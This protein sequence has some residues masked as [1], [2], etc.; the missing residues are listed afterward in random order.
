MS[1]AIDGGVRVATQAAPPPPPPT[2]ARSV[3]AQA[4]DPRTGS[5]DTP[6][7]AQWVADVAR[8]SP[9]TASSAYAGIEAQL[10][11]GDV[12]RLTVDV[13]QAM[14]TPPAPAKREDDQDPTY[15]AYGAGMAPDVA[16]RRVL[17][18]NPLLEVQWRSTTSP[19]TGRSGF[20]G[21]LERAM[22]KAGIRHDFAVAPRPVNGT[23]I[24]TSASKTFNGHAARDAIADQL[25]TDPRYSQVANEADG[26]IVRQTS[27]GE[28]H[29]D[30]TAIRAGAR[31]EDNVRVDVESKLGSA[32]GSRGPKGNLAQVAKDGER[33]LENAGIRRIGAVAE[34]VG[35]VARPAGVVID[36]VQI[37]SAIKADGGTFGDNSQRAAGSLVGG[38]AG[39]WGGAQAGAAIGS[40]GGPVGTVVGGLAG[41]AIGGIVGS[42]VGEK[43]VDWVKGWF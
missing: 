39:A 7:L 5:V 31:P 42:G 6:R 2:D 33:I 16:G 43:A 34:G 25:R 21:P 32:A 26:T 15:S 36:A 11:V 4:T 37:G 8:T 18:D 24:N 28:R 22:D 29:V 30:V 20:S 23:T 9:E 10:S 41:A 14:R 35:K 1:L 12:S 19:V 38:A 17:R 27:M 13:A 3:V 40:L